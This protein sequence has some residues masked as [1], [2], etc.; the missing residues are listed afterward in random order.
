MLEFRRI[1]LKDVVMVL[2]AALILMPAISFAEKNL[3]LAVFAVL[4][5]ASVLT[6]LSRRASVIVSAVI[7]GGIFSIILEFMLDRAANLSITGSLILMGLLFELIAIIG[8]ESEASIF[9]AS[10][11][12]SISFPF[13][14]YL[15]LGIS[16]SQ[17][18]YMLALKSADYLII[19]ISAAILSH[20]LWCFLRQRR[21]VLRFVH[22][23]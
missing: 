10:A 13:I 16:L 1:R 2:V 21:C 17:N 14:A 6:I 18:L 20:L 12:S 7:I 23:R 9:I 4:L 5:V 22:S 8:K 19:G 15:V 3:L 11:I